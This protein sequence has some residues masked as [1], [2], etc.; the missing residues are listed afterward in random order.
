MNGT[1]FQTKQKQTT[2]KRNTKKEVINMRLLIAIFIIAIITDMKYCKIPNLLII[3]GITAG[4]LISIANTQ[5]SEALQSLIC[6]AVIFVSFYPFY[7]LGGL[8]A[9]DI[10]LFMMT[11]CF[12]R[13][14]SL[15]SFILVTML[16]GAAISI[17]KM[18]I[19]QESR[20]RL[21][22]LG[23]YIRKLALTGT[24]D[25]YEI[26]KTNN[27]TII[28]MAAPA[29]ISLILMSAGIYG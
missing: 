23:G 18:I 22:Y 19:F 12:I 13:N 4:L 5:Y 29:F 27:H 24:A 7:L 28:R 20:Q 9:G 3:T 11:G 26:D 25:N 15:L 6:M 16:I 14:E 17:A 2:T 21:F 8:G 10:K 1:T